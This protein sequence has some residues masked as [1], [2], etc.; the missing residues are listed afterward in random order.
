M[1]LSRCHVHAPK[2]FTIATKHLLFYLHGGLGVQRSPPT[3]P[4]LMEMQ[5]C[6]DKE[7]ETANKP[8]LPRYS[9]ARTQRTHPQLIGP[10]VFELGRRGYIVN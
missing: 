7:I 3:E 4:H 2:T 8:H 9:T 10:R 6:G 5:D 1:Y